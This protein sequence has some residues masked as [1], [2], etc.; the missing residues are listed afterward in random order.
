M[1]ITAT[2]GGITHT[3]NSAVTLDFGLVP[4]CYG[5]FEG[6]VTDAVSGDPVAGARITGGAP[7]PR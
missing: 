2:G 7:S 6:V 1:A 4:L 5:A 3:T